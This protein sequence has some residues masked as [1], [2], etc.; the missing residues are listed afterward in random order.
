MCIWGV[1]YLWL[2]CI[3]WSGVPE[4][5]NCALR[6]FVPTKRTLW[7]SLSAT[8]HWKSHFY[9]AAPGSFNHD[10]TTFLQSENKFKQTVGCKILIL[11][12]TLLY[13]IEAKM[14]K[15]LLY[16]SL[17]CIFRFINCILYVAHSTLYIVWCTCTHCTIY[18]EL[19]SMSGD[20]ADRRMAQTAGVQWSAP[21][22]RNILILMNCELWIL[23]NC[24]T[25]SCSVS[26]LEQNLDSDQLRWDKC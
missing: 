9:R 17:Q 26:S 24:A 10:F 21:L 19:T 18:I 11:Y 22:N 13:S 2:L 15:A 6:C 7:C 23:M 25:D 8:K 12:F 20:A 4:L 5:V 1:V 3:W 14:Y 16:C